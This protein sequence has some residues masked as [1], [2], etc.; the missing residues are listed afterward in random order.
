VCVCVLLCARRKAF[1]SSA[2]TRPFE[3]ACPSRLKAHTRAA[4]SGHAMPCHDMQA[5]GCSD[6][7]TRWLAGWTG[8]AGCG[9]GGRWWL[10]T[11]RALCVADAASFASPRHATPCR[12]VAGAVAGSNGR[13]VARRDLL[14][15]GCLRA[16]WGDRR[17]FVCLGGKGMAWLG[18]LIDD[19]VGF[20]GCWG[21][22]LSNLV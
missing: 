22:T 9:G 2:P 4:A 20:P 21:S 11:R 7:Y 3:R 5:D 12:Q 10:R 14:R 13:C 17:E 8:L 16:R 1:F 18:A 19:V 6:G 15:W